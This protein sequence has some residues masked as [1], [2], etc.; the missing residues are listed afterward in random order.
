MDERKHQI[1][2]DFARTILFSVYE[3]AVFVRIVNADVVIFIKAGEDDEV[4]FSC[5]NARTDADDDRDFLF[6]QFEHP[7]FID[8][9]ALEIILTEN[10]IASEGGIGRS[11]AVASGRADF[12]DAVSVIR[13]KFCDGGRIDFLTV[14]TDDHRR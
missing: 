8:F 10:V 9:F 7:A 12:A 2:R 3:I 4:S 6:K 13:K 14:R 1:F 11:L 5:K